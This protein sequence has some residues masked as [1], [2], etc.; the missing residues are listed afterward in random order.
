ML[1]KNYTRK[2]LT[3]KIY[4]TLGFSKNVSSAIIDER[5]STHSLDAVELNCWLTNTVPGRN[6]NPATNATENFN[7]H[8]EGRYL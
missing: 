4:Q 3:N 5:S 2:K 1:K 6:Q 7:A 8:I